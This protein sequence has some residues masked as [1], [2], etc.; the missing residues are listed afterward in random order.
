MRLAAQAKA[1]FFPTPESVYKIIPKYLICNKNKQNG[2][3]VRILDPC[4]GDG[5]PIAHIA[6]TLNENANIE[7]Y[8]IEISQERGKTAQEVL[9]KCLIVDYQ[10][11]RISNQAFNILYLNPPY[12]DDTTGDYEG[13]SRSNRQELMFLKNSIKYIMPNG[14]LVYIIPQMRISRRIAR[15]LSYYFEDVNIFKF[16]LEEFDRFKQVVI[17][18]K[19]KKTA[20]I[21]K[22][23]EKML[24]KHGRMEAYASNISIAWLKHNYEIPQLPTKQRKNILFSTNV[25]EPNDL[26]IETQKFGLID[27]IPQLFGSENIIDLKT[28]PIMPMRHGHLAQALASG[29]MNGIVRDKN[30]ENPL[31]VKGLTRKIT[32]SRKEGSGDNAK[33]IETERVK[34]VVNAFNSNGDL[35]MIE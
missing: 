31:L 21:D 23:I 6:K 8:G 15:V 22:T 9:T 17:I 7:T 34:I 19:R 14:I 33:I 29:I 27:D 10:N 28:R 1:G 30:N 4:A 24:V 20:V 16:P 32:N 26:V 35:L 12:D 3:L 5:E 2:G 13:L 25:I 18:A 11:T